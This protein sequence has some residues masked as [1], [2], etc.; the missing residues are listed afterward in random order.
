MLDVVDEISPLPAKQLLKMHYGK[1]FALSPVAEVT[2]SIDPSRNRL[3]IVD[4]SNITDRQGINNHWSLAPKERVQ[5][6]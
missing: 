4:Y 2:D 1:Y 3:K 5:S 6:S